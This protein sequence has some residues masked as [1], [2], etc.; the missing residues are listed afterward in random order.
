MKSIRRSIRN[1]RKSTWAIVFTVAFIMGVTYGLHEWLGTNDWAGLGQW[2][3]GLGA[4]VAAW[5]AL[6]I[7]SDERR[8]E[9]RRDADQARVRA[10]YIRIRLTQTALGTGFRLEIENLSTEP[11][12]NVEVVAMRFKVDGDDNDIIIPMSTVDGYRAVLLPTKPE[13]WQPWVIPANEPF[14]QGFVEKF[15]GGRTD[16]EVAFEDLSGMR[17]RR[18]GNRIPT[19]AL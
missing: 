8:R 17:W 2:F 11:I 10:H 12:L 16:F 7:A 3:G 1:V 6:R 15:R 14:T 5:A 4:L 9:R 19:Q 13:I 18:I